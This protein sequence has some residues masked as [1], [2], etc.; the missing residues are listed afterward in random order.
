MDDIFDKEKN[1]AFGD[2]GKTVIFVHKACQ[3]N[4]EESLWAEADYIEQAKKGYGTESSEPYYLEEMRKAAAT[5]K[6]FI[7]MEFDPY[8]CG[9]IETLITRANG[10]YNFYHWC[11]YI[12][13]H[14]DACPPGEEASPLYNLNEEKLAILRPLYYSEF[15]L[16][17]TMP[18]GHTITL[19][20]LKKLKNVNTGPETTAEE[21]REFVENFKKGILQKPVYEFYEIDNLTMINYI[22]RKM[23]DAIR[24][25]NRL[26]QTARQW[27]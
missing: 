1:R 10:Q 23:R 13:F 9:V 18:V 22:D 12:F 3:F 11:F 7:I 15:I 16:K 19:A 20:E 25:H 2:S 5:N 27:V 14:A 6:R 21:F 17:Y 4:I 26:K 8:I 24:D